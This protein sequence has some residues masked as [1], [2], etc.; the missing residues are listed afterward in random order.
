MIDILKKTMLAGVGAVVITKDKVEAALG[1]LVKQGKLSA[2]EARQTAEKIATEGKREF[3]TLSHDLAEKINDRLTPTDRK[4]QERLD[5]LEARIAALE[6]AAGFAPASTPA[7]DAGE[8]TPPAPG[9][10]TATPPDANA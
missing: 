8:A 6:R 4:A 9:P 10:D 1:D 7:C 2:S 5:A 3:E